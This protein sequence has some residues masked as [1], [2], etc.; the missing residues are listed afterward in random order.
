MNFAP[1][2]LA[3]IDALAALT[4]TPGALTRTFL[5]PAQ[6]RASETVLRWMREAGMSA[7]IDAIGN[8]VG[9][10][11]GTKPSLPALILGSHLD[12][13]RNA[14]KYDGMLGV[15]TAIE[16]VSALHRE[17]VR[18]PFAIEIYGFADEE[19]VR[20]GATLLGSRAAAG[21]FDAKA[22]ALR[23]AE[24]TEMAEA[25]S[26]Y[27]LDPALLSSAARRR[28][29]VLAFVELHIEQGPV[30]EARGLAV[31]CVTSIAGATRLAV[32]FAGEAGH[33]GT[34][35]MGG[36]RD[37]L[38]AAA[39]A[40]LAVERCGGASPGLVAT[41]GKIEALPGAV[42]VIPGAARFTVDIR[43][44]A[45]L[46]RR[47]A[48]A[49]ISAAIA[50]IAGRRGIGCEISTTH[51]APAAPCAPWLQDAIDRA[52]AAAGVTPFRLPSGAGHDAMAMIAL[53]DIGM[54]FLRCAR[55]ISHDP[56]E[57]VTAEDVEL[58]A[59]V[60]LRFIRDFQPK[61]RP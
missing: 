36:R 35:P 1:A 32:S 27:G 34:V 8:V 15:V 23:D 58:G 49:A 44:P 5:S 17:G 18:L 54:I 50:E 38:A 12:T 25:L 56:A 45:D 59:R 13:V 6:R 22:L 57:A 51:D 11:K 30:L 16:C 37:A 3:R 4:E 43:A 53:A 2:I 29:D 60:L 19:G 39:E 31:G 9:R 24:G 26:R 41:V 20:F 21:T 61:D 10:Y 40:V 48:T 33:A 47:D 14:G 28:E 55:G 7:R 46:P 42:N 52:I